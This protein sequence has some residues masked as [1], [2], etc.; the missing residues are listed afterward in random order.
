MASSHRTSF[1]SKSRGFNRSKNN[2]SDSQKEM[3]KPLL[4]DESQANSG[5]LHFKPQINSSKDSSDDDVDRQ[6]SPNDDFMMIEFDQF[7]QIPFLRKMRWFHAFFF[8][9]FTVTIFRVIINILVFMADLNGAKGSIF[10]EY[11]VFASASELGSCIILIIYYRSV[12]NNVTEGHASPPLL[13][14]VQSPPTN[15]QAEGPEIAID[16]TGVDPG[17]ANSDA[18]YGKLAS[19][20]KLIPHNSK[21]TGREII[22]EYSNTIVD[23]S[24]SNGTGSSTSIKDKDLDIM[25]RRRTMLKMLESEPR[26][27]NLLLESSDS[28]NAGISPQKG[29]GQQTGRQSLY[30]D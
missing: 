13:R 26:T 25:S 22:T 16:Q 19:K 15:Q 5:S 30:R 24:S 21:A 28:Y 6:E 29:T 23:N 7:E 2:Q 3:A 10:L 11:A 27:N 8:G 18:P 4:V 14:N 12:I 9:I 17:R 1:L 20:P